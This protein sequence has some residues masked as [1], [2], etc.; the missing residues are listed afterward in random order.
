[1][2]AFGTVLNDQIN[3]GVKR[4]SN[5]VYSEILSMPY[6][7]SASALQELASHLQ[8]RKHIMLRLERILCSEYGFRL[9]WEAD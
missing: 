9:N 4:L 7:R 8:S 1:M 2:K 3:A 5:N 6:A